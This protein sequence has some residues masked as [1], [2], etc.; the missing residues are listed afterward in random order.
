MT[1]IAS[2][3]SLRWW[4]ASYPATALVAVESPTRDTIAD[5]GAT[6][7]FVTEGTPVKN[8]RCTTCPLKVTL[9]DGQQVWTT[10]M[11]DIDI[12]GLPYT[13]IGHI[14][15]NLSIACLFGI[16]VLTAVGCTVTFDNNKCIVTFNGKEILHGYKDPRTDLW[17]LPLNNG[18]TLTTAQ[19]DTVM[20]VLGSPNMA[21]AHTSLFMQ[22]TSTAPQS[23]LF[24]HTI[25]NRAKS[26]KFTHQSLC[27]L[28][29]LTL[30]KAIRCGFLKGCPNLTTAGVTRYLNP[31]PAS[32]KGHVK[33]PHQGICSMW[34]RQ[35]RG[36]ITTLVPAPQLVAPVLPLF[37]DTPPYPGPAYGTQSFPNPYNDAS[38][39]FDPSIDTGP[40]GVIIIADDNS[41]KEGNIFCFGAFADKHTGRYGAHVRGSK[42][43]KKPQIKSFLN[44]RLWVFDPAYKD[45]NAIQN[46]LSICY[47]T[48]RTPPANYILT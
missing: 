44:D 13:L 32:A 38:L 9:A 40:P 47:S 22:A 14:I 33:R 25:H 46:H 17:T 30:L 21:S 48:S 27:S 34:S 18:K 7:I 11:C 42:T 12:P 20:P 37:Q 15:P 16:R 41:T 3:V 36:T 5:S 35:I 23:A 4:L 1:I 28:Q 31:S 8:K 45:T 26:I 6:Q 2:N 10:N 24:T 19:H 29:I 43:L 39:A